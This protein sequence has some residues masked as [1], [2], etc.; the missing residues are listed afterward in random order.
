MA[1]SLYMIM[2]AVVVMVAVVHGSSGVPGI[3]QF[4]FLPARLGCCFCCAGP[5]RSTLAAVALVAGWCFWMF[6]AQHVTDLLVLG[7][8]NLVCFLYLVRTDVREKLR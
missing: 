4:S 6:V 3:F 7:L 5:G 8:I 1:I 2:L